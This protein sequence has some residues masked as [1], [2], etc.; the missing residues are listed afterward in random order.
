[1][2]NKQGEAAKARCAASCH[3]AR[4]WCSID[5]NI[6][7]HYQ[8]QET[9]MLNAFALIPLCAGLLLGLTG[10]TQ[11]ASYEYRF[12]SNPGAHEVAPDK[13][14]D[15]LFTFGFTDVA[16]NA[17][18]LDLASSWRSGDV[19]LKATYQDKTVNLAEG[20]QLGDHGLIFADNEGMI[21]TYEGNF[22]DV[23]LDPGSSF[24]VQHQLPF[25][26]FVYGQ[27]MA[28]AGQAD[29]VAASAVWLDGDHASLAAHAVPEPSSWACTII[30]LA[31]LGCMANSR[32]R[33]K[34][35]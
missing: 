1:M 19:W 30:G 17:G 3:G 35:A 21:E 28:Y 32:R 26:P 2:H 22:L 11:A 8:I 33:V 29:H 18:E 13:S 5:G 15:V 7:I 34:T 25:D 24:V 23:D 27:L 10:Q 9:I 6:R 14:L 12:I 20:I 4:T 31:A 16:L